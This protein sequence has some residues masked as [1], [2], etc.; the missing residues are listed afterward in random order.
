[1]SHDGVLHL[2]L[3]LKFRPS[4]LIGPGNSWANTMTVEQAWIP[5][6]GVLPCLRLR[7]SAVAIDVV[8]G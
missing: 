7:S 2:L 4:V 3:R 1:M 6:L 5:W 8:S